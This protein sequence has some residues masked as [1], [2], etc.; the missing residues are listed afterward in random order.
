MTN[1]LPHPLAPE[2]RVV[3]GRDLAVLIASLLL[4][5]APHAE[6][7]PWWITLLVPSLYGWRVYLGVTHTPLPP[8]WLL[9]ALTGVA[10]TGIWIQ[11]HT[12]FGRSPGIVL[13][14]LFSGL[15]LMEMRSRR[16]ATVVAFL[17]FFLIITNFF[18]SQ[19][20][21]IALTM[22]VA[23]VAITTA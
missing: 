16:D 11:Y 20:I 12:I 19:S 9:L 6:H 23:L 21:P 14:C 4:V 13:L 7:A 1:A 3:N 22:C 5:V 2:L 15:K 10:M 8:R 18:N 17:C